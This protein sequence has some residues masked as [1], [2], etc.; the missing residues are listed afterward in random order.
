MIKNYFL[1]L[2]LV[3]VFFSCRK[4]KTD[5]NSNWTAPIVN[6]TL[7]FKNLVNDSTIAEAATIY[8]LD[9]TRTLLNVGIEEFLEIPDTTIDQSYSIVVPSLSI[10]PGFSIVNQVEEHTMDLDPIQLK[11]IRV[12]KG[13]IKLKIY[14]PVPEKVYFTVQLPGV[15]HMGVEFAQNYFAPA[16]V[17]SSPGTVEAQLDISGYDINLTGVSGGEVNVLQSKLVINTDPFGAS[18]T[19]TNQQVFKVEARF[20]KIKVD[21]AK[22]YFGHKIISDTLIQS[23]DLLNG[24]VAG[25]IDLPESAIQ[26]EISNGMKIEGRATIT[27]LTNTNTLGSTVAMSNSQIGSPIYLDAATG[28]VSSFTNAMQ[29]ISFD[30]SNSNLEQY[31]ENLGNKHTI[32]YKIELNP[33]GNTS[34]G[35]NEIFPESRLKVKFKAQMPMTIGAD[36]LV[37][38]DTFDFDVEQDLTK[39]HIESGVLVLDASNAFPMSA[40]VKLYL[41]DENGNLLNMV[42]GSSKIESSLYGFVDPKDNKLKSNSTVNFVLTEAALTNLSTVKKIA[43]E[44]EFN[45]TN[46]SSSLNE[47]IGIPIGAFIAVKLKA[48]LNLKVIY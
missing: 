29:T 4:E 30:G 37:L 42:N 18:V 19:V 34:G 17:G 2:A 24:L 15:T 12:S 32:G 47:Q 48:K 23:I 38:R 33:W 5:W 35:N 27:K 1:L 11:K 40:N 9:L 22:G 28:N 41:L 43:V 6:D 36:G 14:N 13:V 45:T 3:L 7:S 26:F 20:E 39:S 10:P 21:Y 16:A 31:L 46:P 8:T 44:S 25:S